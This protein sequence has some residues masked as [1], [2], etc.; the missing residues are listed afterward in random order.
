MGLLL[1]KVTSPGSQDMPCPPPRGS[2]HSVP[3]TGDR[4]I[5]QHMGVPT[6][7]GC[8]CLPPW[9]AACFTWERTVGLLLLHFVLVLPG[10]G[11]VEAKL[12]AALV[13]TAGA[14]LREAR[15][16]EV[17][18]PPRGHLVGYAPL[19]QSLCTHLLSGVDNGTQPMDVQQPLQLLA[20]H[21]Q[22]TMQRFLL[23]R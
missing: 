3:R 22:G 9:H 11:D 15:L 12:E 7:V 21:T 18:Q 1:T 20:Q 23:L 16:S 10:L 4:W 8:A 13:G 19:P 6:S 14:F 5:G 17:L 2:L